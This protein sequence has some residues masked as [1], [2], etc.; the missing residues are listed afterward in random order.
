[1][2]DIKNTPLSFLIDKLDVTKIFDK[3]DFIKNCAKGAALF[4]FISC[5]IGLENYRKSFYDSE[6][7]IKKINNKNKLNEERID[8]LIK[9]NKQIFEILEKQNKI[10]N[11]INETPLFNLSSRPTLSKSSS[12]LSFILEVSPQ[13]NIKANELSDQE[14]LNECYD[15]LPCNNSKK[16]TGLNKLFNW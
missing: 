14:M 4:T 1:M 6:E 5:L 16:I 12:N 15:N 3:V 8:E 7:I 13:K 9:I 2:S 11:E 10:L